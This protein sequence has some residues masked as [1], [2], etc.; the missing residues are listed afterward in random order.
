MPSL[1]SGFEYD[2]F[3]SYRQKDNKHDGWVTEFVNNLKGELEATFKEDVSVY[4]D[5]NPHDGLLE[6]HDVN[7]SLEEKLKCLIFIPIISRTYCDTKSFAWEH[8]FKAFVEQASKDQ[9]GLKVKL[10]NGNIASRVLPV[11]IYDLDTNDIEL[12]DSI[13]GGVL[14]SVDFIYKSSG[15]NRPLRANEDHPQYNLNKTYY[16]DQINKVANSIKDIITAIGKHIPQKGE[17]SKDVSKPMM[18]LQKNSKTKII[19]TSVVILALIVAGFFISP[20]LF[21]P[22][23]QLELSIAVLPF[24]NDSPEQENTYFINGIMEEVNNNLQKIKELRVLSRTSVEQYRGTTKPSVPKIAKEIDVNYIVEGS[25]QKY[26]NKFVLRVQLIAAK[27]ERHIWAKSYEKEIKATSD[28]ISIQSEIAQSIASELRATITPEEKQI[29]EKTP[30][31]NLTAYDLYLKANDYRMNYY[32]TGNSSSLQKAITFYKAALELDSA[33]AK[34]YTALAGIYYNRYY[35]KTYFQQNFLDSCLILANIALSFDDQM[36]EAYYMKGMFYL[37]KGNFQEALNNYDKTLIINPNHFG[38]YYSKGR[39]LISIV[40]DYEKG[41]ENYQ[42][43][44]NLIRGKER[45]SILHPLGDAYLDF[46][47]IDKAKECYQ[48]KYSLDSNKVSYFFNLGWIEFS[49]GNFEENLKLYKNA[50]EV[51]SSVSF[52]LMHYSIPFGHNE[53]AYICAKKLVEYYKKSGALNLQQAHRIGYAFWQVGKC[54]EAEDYLNQQIKYDEEIIKLGRELAQNKSAQYDL[55]ATYAFLG[56]KEKAY[57][58]LNDFS[59]KKFF[60]LWWISLA[61][62]DPLFASIRNE[63]RFQKI[64]KNMEAIYQA[65]HERVR[66]WLEEQGML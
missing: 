44:L 17:V 64:L 23:R 12:C 46:G 41:I 62:H 25:G 26:G 51:D 2:I 29:I 49:L 16:R 6:T 39:I 21:K 31:T 9:Y 4:F 30:T 27:N 61:K 20:K 22:T 47:F 50:Q 65:E 15:V 10:P 14:R 24:I 7:A 57:Q 54:K 1:I 66:K 11:K 55:A 52:D 38:A 19:I 60:P 32:H 36:D 56:N 59:T 28:Q 37:M 58:Y 40:E 13:L 34:A 18:I 3:I 45:L 35:S 53:E 42:K 33:F 5:I 8:E 48:E 63:E 43:G